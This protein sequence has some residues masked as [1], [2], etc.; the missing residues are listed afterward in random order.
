MGDFLIFTPCGSPSFKLILLYILNINHLK[1]NLFMKNSKTY[2]IIVLLSFIVGT[3]G[4]SDKAHEEPDSITLEFTSKTISSTGEI[5]PV[6]LKTNTK[7]NASSSK[8]WITLTPS[9]GNGDALVEVSVEANKTTLADYGII[10]FTAGTAT[11]NLTINRSGASPALSI[12]PVGEINVPAGGQTLAVTVTS[13]TDWTVSSDQTWAKADVESGKENGTVAIKVEVNETIDADRAVITFATESVTQTLTINRSGANPALNISPVGELEVSAGGQT[14][15]VT[16]TSNTDW[17]VSSDQIWAEPNVQSGKKNA[18]VS[19]KVDANA[20][21][22]ADRAIVTFV[23]ESVTQTLVINR[24]GATP[25]LT[26]SPSGE[27]NVPAEGRTIAV[28]V[29]SNT[30]WTVNSGESWATPD[31]QGGK[32]NGTVNI[33]VDANEAVKSDKAVITFTTGT[34]TQTLTILRAGIPVELS[35]SPEEPQH[36]PYV[37]GNIRF[38]VLSN[39]N[40]SIISS[41]DWAQPSVS[42][43]DGK[44]SCTVTVQPNSLAEQQ[45]A[46]L[47]FKAENLTK[48]VSIYLAPAPIALEIVPTEPQNFPSKGGEVTVEVVANAVWQVSSNRTWVSV[49]R[50][51]G[52][53]N[54]SVKI[55]VAPSGKTDTE[56]SAVVTF[57]AGNLT[58]QVVINRAVFAFIDINISD[59]QTVPA[60]GIKFDVSVTSN[61]DWTVHSDKTW[62]IP[63]PASGSG[64]AI[65]NIEVLPNAFSAEEEAVVWFETQDETKSFKIKRLGQTYTLGSPYPNAE[66]PIGIVYQISDGGKHGKVISL[67]VCTFSWGSEYL[68][69]GATDPD[70]GDKNMD[71]IKAIE[72]WEWRYPLFKWC[73][74]L[75]SKWY[76][77]SKNELNAI[78]SAKYAINQGMVAIQKGTAIKDWDW[79]WSSTEYSFDKAQCISLAGY[80]PSI[81]IIDKKETKYFNSRAILVF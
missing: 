75:G 7:W 51:E 53:G 14:I 54:G 21:V 16:V 76:I 26:I 52:K 74:D 36:I 66:Q 38:T 18:T 42:T 10:T 59:T 45:L 22:E 64:N 13:N 50:K 49:D 23:T 39:T 11:Q 60:D 37:G 80:S 19:I 35:V 4:C 32:E 67:D 68:A 79:I 81:L 61:A 47:T 62:I 77:P 43:G 27:L 9:G 58:R 15:A 41:A 73:T 56:E 72:G 78:A 40:W 55:T 8:S 63:Y 3:L 57:T 2:W 70:R 48:T 46:S 30:E 34:I 65:C 44:G 6:S 31:I 5:F 69:T 33:C 29:M 12:S 24:S 17:T 20:A 1:E 71:K 25:V 28:A